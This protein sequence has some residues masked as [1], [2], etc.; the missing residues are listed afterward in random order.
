MSP[1]ASRRLD[2]ETEALNLHSATRYFDA[3]RSIAAR[4]FVEEATERLQRAAIAYAVAYDEAP[5]RRQAKRG[6]AR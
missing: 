4:R 6:A 5:K 3:D 1:L 2:L